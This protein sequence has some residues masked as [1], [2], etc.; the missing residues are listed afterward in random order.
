MKRIFWFIMAA[1]PL[2]SCEKNDVVDLPQGQPLLVVQG[3][4]TDQPGPYTVTLT[5][6]GPYFNEADLP[7]V[8]GAEVVLQDAQGPSETLRETS[9]GTYVSQGTVQ[10][11]IGGQYSLTI[12]SEGERYRAETE[13]RRIAPID[14]LKA[15]FRPQA[16][17]T[18]SGYYVLYYGPELRGPGDYLRI[19]L[20]RNGQLLNQ[21]ADLM[22]ST[23][24]LVDGK[25]L[26][27]LRL[28]AKP[29]AKGDVIRVEANAL[30]A[31]YYYFLRELSLQIN[32][33]GLF[34]TPPANV[35]T[36]VQNL[37]SG[38]DRPAVGYFAG[39]AVRAAAVRIR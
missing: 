2:I 10:G 29:F 16:G 5:K 17:L 30:T 25:Y 24:E 35:R 19:K 27:G 37:S 36:N 33:G 38:A 3:A 26:N 18:D 1:L 6:T 34:A 22:L 11:R 23:D 14:S 12:R 4:I 8:R 13:I 7:R 32:N 15:E 20:F 31:D 21:P 28:N 39:Y 9:P